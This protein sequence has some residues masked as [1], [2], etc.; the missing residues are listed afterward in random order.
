MKQIAIGCLA[1]VV[2]MAVFLTAVGLWL[3]R[4]LPVLTPSIS[5]PSVVQLDSEL[6]LVVTASNS[7]TESIVLDSID[8][9]DSFLEG[10]QVVEIAPVPKDTMHIFGMRS[11]EFGITVSPGESQEV[12]FTM[13]AVQEGHFSGDV[14]VCNPN[15]DFTTVIADVVVREDSDGQ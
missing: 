14:D 3:L 4:E 1:A 7:H 2:L 10:F 13:K 6:K 12:E 9:D 11:W 15:Q 5:A 8:I